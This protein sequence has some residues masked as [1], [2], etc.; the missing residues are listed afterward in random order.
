LNPRYA[1]PPARPSPGYTPSIVGWQGRA[2]LH[3]EGRDQRGVASLADLIAGHLARSGLV[4]LTTHQDVPIAGQVEKLT[5]V[6]AA[7]P[8]E[9]DA[10]REV[11]A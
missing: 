4:I 2:E 8:G 3:L 6:P 5:L 7:A 11:P 9:P 1:P 10:P